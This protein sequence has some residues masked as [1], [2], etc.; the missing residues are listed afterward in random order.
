M[1]VS[2]PHLLAAAKAEKVRSV[3][4]D[5]KKTQDETWRQIN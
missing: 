5:I 3:L 4:Y 1:T 2:D